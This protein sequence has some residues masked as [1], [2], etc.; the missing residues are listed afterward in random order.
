MRTV[1]SLTNVCAGSGEL[2]W[3]SCRIGAFLWFY[4]LHQQH[5]TGKEIQQ[6]YLS[7][8]KSKGIVSCWS[9]ALFFLYLSYR[10]RTTTPWKICS[11]PVWKSPLRCWFT[12]Q[13][14]WS[15]GS[16][17]SPPATCGEAKACL[18]SPFVSAALREPMRMFG[19]CW[20]VSPKLE[21]VFY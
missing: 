9:C 11:N 10:T 15:C 4:R 18:V 2:T 5:A 6:L 19:M 20:W 21:S 8:A 16:Q 13:R 17:Q 3:T 14:P 12:P 7:G 1:S